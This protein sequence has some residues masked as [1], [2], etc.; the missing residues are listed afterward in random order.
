MMYM[1]LWTAFYVVYVL[2]L[3]SVLKLEQLL[4][5]QQLLSQ[6]L[7]LHQRQHVLLVVRMRAAAAA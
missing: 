3:V 5:L 1:D 4:L 7:G 6:Q 2:C